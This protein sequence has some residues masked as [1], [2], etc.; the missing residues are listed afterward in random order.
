MFSKTGKPILVP[1]YSVLQD[2]FFQA[3]QRAGY[4]DI[5]RGKKGSTEEHLT[6]TQFKVQAERKRLEALQA[7]SHT[8]EETLSQLQEEQH[9]AEESLSR[10]HQKQH[11]AEQELEKLRE[12]NY[13]AEEALDLIREKQH[14]ARAKA[15][16]A[17]QKMEE[18]APKLEAIEKVAKEFSEDPEQILPQAG[19]LESAKTYRE[20]KAKPFWSKIVTVLRSLYRAY[21]DLKE[22]YDALQQRFFRECMRNDDLHDRID[23]LTEQNKHLTA[24]NKQSTQALKTL[25]QAFGKEK[26]EATI[27]STNQHTP[28]K[29]SISKGDINRFND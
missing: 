14:S 12:E 1:S 25:K 11:S 15:D 22:R 21:M 28:A 9:S 6:V 17:M 20:K 18:I 19:A 23:E 4:T 8:A 16:E 26:V 29:P 27:K 3:M 13:A 7:Q 24:Q 2:T 10:I 5:E